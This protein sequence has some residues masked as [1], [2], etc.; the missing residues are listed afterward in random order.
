MARE[1]RGV[2]V[3]TVAN[4]DW[5]SAPGLSPWQQQIE[6][7][8]ILNK[9]V[10]MHLNAIIL[11]VRPAADALYASPYEPWSEY[12]TGQM[13]APPEPFYD[14]LAF[15]IA[16][17]HKRGLELHA[18]INPFRAH[19]PSATSPLA[20]THVREAEPGMVRQYG[21]YLWLDPGDPAARRH[22]LRVVLDIVRRYDV[23]G[24]HIDDYFY[25]YQERDSLGRPLSFPD[26]A[27]WKRYVRAGGTL[28]RD[29]WRRHNIDRFIEAMYREVKAVKPWVKVGISP[30]GIWRP[31]F[32]EQVA[33]FD[34]Y[35]ELYAD[36][37]KWLTNG[38]L[39]YLSPQ[40]Y[41]SIGR[42]QQ[43]YPVLL[44]WWVSQNVHGRHI[45]PGNYASRVGPLGTSSWPVDELLQQI[46]LTREQPGATGNVYFSMSAFLRNQGGITDQLMAGPY[47]GPALVPASPWLSRSRPPAP[48]AVARADTVTGNL[49][50]H[51]APATEHEP[52]LWVVQARNAGEWTTA[53]LP[54]V[55]RAYTLRRAPSL[56]G[57]DVVAV[58]EVNR[59]GNQSPDTVLHLPPASTAARRDS[60][61]TAVPK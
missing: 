44:A 22:S 53:I 60:T 45:W 36:S 28:S 15:A 3:A 9:A 4:I 24:I 49:V 50:L 6:L 33:G 18:W 11:Q 41:W 61:G 31:G 12:L 35:A 26:E 42:P 52:W 21:D 8:E 46:R 58:S 43:S 14:P 38:W 19:H 48:R 7:L 51:I 20:T 13:G 40:L 39:D 47:Q 54:G 34:A 32:P 56:T 17:A 1:F 16:E 25:P 27:S 59:Y 37:R 23:D 10:E 5:P 55:Q 30:F 2:W 29:D 57:P